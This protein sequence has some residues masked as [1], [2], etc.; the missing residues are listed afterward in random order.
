MNKF[1]LLILILAAASIVACA[2]NDKHQHSGMRTSAQIKV[3][4]DATTDQ[5]TIEI[6]ARNGTAPSMLKWTSDD[7]SA[8][9]KVEFTEA[10]QPCVVDLMCSGGVCTAASNVNFRGATSA[11]CHYRTSVGT[12]THDPIVII[13]NCCP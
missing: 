5:E 7:P 12:A 4:N 8:I 1:R 2:S 3:H 11:R 13:D 6:Q 10:G 9:L